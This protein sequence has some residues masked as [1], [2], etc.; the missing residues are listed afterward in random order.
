MALGQPPRE[1]TGLHAR[2]R[3]KAFRRRRDGRD[4]VARRATGA[5]QPRA[6][7]GAFDE[8]SARLRQRTAI[9]QGRQTQ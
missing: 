8:D 5:R 6:G 2:H 4:R 1:G 3:S 9:R 7:T